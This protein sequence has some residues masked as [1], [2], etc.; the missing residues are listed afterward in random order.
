MP[1]DVEHQHHDS[2][3]SGQLL[4]SDARVAAQTTD[5]KW[6]VT[7]P[8][9]DFIPSPPMGLVDVFLRTDCRYGIVDP[10]QWPQT[11]VDDYEYLAAILRTETADTTLSP[12]WWS[13][14]KDD[15]ELI[16]GSVIKCLGLLRRTAIQPLSDL[17]DTLS[18]TIHR[19]PYQ[20][21]HR[22]SDIEAAMQRAR[23]R[24]LCFPCT[25]RDV[26][27]QVRLTQRY[28]LMG[29]AFLD[30]YAVY[31]PTGSNRPVNKDFMGTFTTDPE[32]VQQLF[33]AGIPVW[34]L[35]LDLSILSGTKVGAIVVL[36]EADHIC[37]DIAPGCHDALYHGLSGPQHLKAVSRGSHT[38]QDLSRTVLLAVQTDRGYGGPP[39]Q[40]E[41]K[42]GVMVAPDA[43]PS[44]GGKMQV[45]A[46]PPRARAHPC[47]RADSL[48]SFCQES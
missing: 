45:K 1:R 31:P 39:S 22:L 43:S 32:A 34:W 37:I 25:W 36:I 17:V 9:M 42:S 2:D 46:P 40:K 47:K 5:A 13:P 20:P 44:R 18:N 10:V 21:D 7:S 35:R 28:W 14:Q 48:F 6:V 15:F 16:Q 29:R 4:W 24:L 12:I 8:N 38:Y 26:C 27:L 19:L 3:C 11:F 30:F 33:A 41:F 23:E